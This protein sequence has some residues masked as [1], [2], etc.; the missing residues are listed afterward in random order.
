VSEPQPDEA[1][2]ERTEVRI[3]RA[4]KLG[5]FV[6]IGALVGML[7]TLILTS[8]FPADPEVG[9]AASFGFFLLFGVPAGVALGAAVGLIIDAVSR[10]RGRTVTVQREVVD[11][12]AEAE[13][14]A[15]AEA[16]PED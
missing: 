11:A 6:V 12:P 5:V 8:Q 15:E 2:V 16:P 1:Q 14:H 13:A 4:P 7:T 9:F 3:R 10:R